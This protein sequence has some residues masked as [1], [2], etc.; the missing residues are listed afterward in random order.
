M[1]LRFVRRVP[2]S[3][4]LISAVLR[5]AAILLLA[6]AIT[7]PVSA[8]AVPASEQTVQDLLAELV[9]EV[10]MLRNSLSQ[11]SAR[12][13]RIQIEVERYRVQTD[14]VNLVASRLEDTRTEL[15]ATV[16]SVVQ[17]SHQFESG[18]AEL[19]MTTDLTRRLDLESA[20][21]QATTNLEERRR[22]ESQLREKE[23][24][25]VDSLRVEEAKLATINSR[26]D[27]MEGQLQA[28]ETA[29]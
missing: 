3:A 19:T 24:R 4:T 20:V 17:F 18:Q 11:T 27:A 28:I 29:K 7:G 15:A 6:I 26:L 10:R 12:Q 23:A 9:G 14:T 8:Q 2:A 22:Q 25:L 5:V 16:D 1:F 13:S 21:K